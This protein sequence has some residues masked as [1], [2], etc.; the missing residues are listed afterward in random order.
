MMV[1]VMNVWWGFPIWIA[2]ILAILIAGV[3]GAINSFLSAI[4]E[5]NP[6]VITM[7]M[8]TLLAGV[9]LLIS[10]AMT[11]TGIDQALKNAVYTG[12]LFGISYVFYYAILL[13]GILFYF[14]TFTA[15]GRKV[16][17]VGNGRNV[18]RLSGINVKAVR[19]LCFVASGSLAG[20]A[21]V[22]YAGMLGAADPTSGLSYLM[23][24]F[25]AV[26]L[27]TTVISPGFYNSWGCVIAVYFLVT[28][29]TG[30]SLMGISAAVQNVF[31]GAA[32][33]VA[34]TCS[35][36]VK[37][38][39]SKSELKSILAMEKAAQQGISAANGENKSQ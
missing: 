11:I 32:L 30:L 2:V 14:F 3:I 23:P 34:V 12:R 31:Y 29:T 28:G 8:Q 37:R 20:V 25:A 21:G 4:I 19:F 13:A 9:V 38:N 24:S 22:L 18:A 16:L 7:G 5:L 26:F 27:S 10:D 39:Q 15:A 1:A 36:L 33:V 6:F 35:E 17:I